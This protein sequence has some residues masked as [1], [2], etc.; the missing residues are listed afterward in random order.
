ML[1]EDEIA[2]FEEKIN[3]EVAKAAKRFGESFDEAMFRQ[4]N[5]RVLEHQR[6]RDELHNRF[7]EAMNANDLAELKQIILDYEIADPISGTRNWTDVRQFN[8][9]FKTEMGSTADGA[10][11][12][13]S[14]GDS[15]G[16]FRQL[17]QRAENR[18]HAS[19]FRHSPDRQ[20]I[21]QRDCRPPVHL[22][23]A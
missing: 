10:I 15:P 16:Y 2:K 9:M 21:P 11:D 4:T 20:G 8:L 17:P 18:S 6:K 23:H 22:P 14:S 12:L 13:S 1:I 19:S 7:S 3:K 5:P